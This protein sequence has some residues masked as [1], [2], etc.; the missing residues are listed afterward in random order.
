[1]LAEQWIQALGVRRHGIGGGPPAIGGMA[2]SAVARV[3]TCGELPPMD[4]LMTGLTLHVR[5]RGL[6]I[7]GLMALVAGHRRVLAEQRDLG[8]GMVERRDGV[9][10]GLPGRIVM[11]RIA[12]GGKRAAMRVLVTI[13]ALRE[14]DAG[15]AD[16]L[17][18]RIGRGQRG[19]ALRA[20]HL[21]VG[22]GKFIFSRG[23][24]ESRDVFPFRGRV[25]NRVTTLAFLAQLTFVPIF[26]ARHASCAYRK[27]GAKVNWARNA[28]VVTR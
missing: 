21:G 24:V 27:I 19:V 6:E 28:S 13:A 5:H 3:G 9:S 7:G 15:I 1:M 22:A 12:A 14:G 25:G 17:G 26:V 2:A 23:V 18:G 20:L 10:G 11:A 8:F 4:V 16:D